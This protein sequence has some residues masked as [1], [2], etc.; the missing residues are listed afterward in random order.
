MHYC[1]E[2]SQHDF[3]L[4]VQQTSVDATVL[5]AV[6]VVTQTPPPNGIPGTPQAGLASPGA[7]FASF[8]PVAPLPAPVPQSVVSISIVLISYSL[9]EHHLQTE[10]R[11]LHMRGHDTGRVWRGRLQTSKG[12]GKHDV[13]SRKP[14]LAKLNL[15]LKLFNYFYRN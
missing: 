13:L 11:G 2:C 7:D 8:S 4:T 6:T 9:T 10:E 15:N 14:D 1:N 5:P 12:A 3:S